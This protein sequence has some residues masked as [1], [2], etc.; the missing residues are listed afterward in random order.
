MLLKHHRPPL[1]G[2]VNSTIL[3]RSSDVFMPNQKRSKDAVI[4][5]LKIQRLSL[6]LNRIR[7]LEYKCLHD[8]DRIFEDKT[9][10]LP[11]SLRWSS[12]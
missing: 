6:S 3:A 5:S 12:T 2:G 10:F 8:A 9:T 11:V 4:R 7:R 1:A